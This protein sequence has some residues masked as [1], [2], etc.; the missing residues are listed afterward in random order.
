MNEGEANIFAPSNFV[1]KFGEGVF[2]QLCDQVKFTVRFRKKVQR[3]I[4]DSVVWINEKNKEARYFQ[5]EP[6]TKN[7]NGRGMD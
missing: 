2:K 3:L 7:T 1:Q 5:K 6:K 4:W